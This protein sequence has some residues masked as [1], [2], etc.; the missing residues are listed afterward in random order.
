MQTYELSKGWVLRQTP[1]NEDSEWLAVERVP[2]NVH[3]DLIANDKYV[4]YPPG[5]NDN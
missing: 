1:S 4:C 3:L 5:G 2:T